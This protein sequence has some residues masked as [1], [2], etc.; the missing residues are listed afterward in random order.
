MRLL[1][2]LVRPKFFIPVHGNYGNLRK[3]AQSPWRPA[4]SSTPS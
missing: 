4:P 2:N 3:H 1:I